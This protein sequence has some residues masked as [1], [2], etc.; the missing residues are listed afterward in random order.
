MLTDKRTEKY[1]SHLNFEQQKRELFSSLRYASYIQNALMP[2]NQ[3]IS[4]CFPEHFIFFQPR[5]IVS[6]DFYWLF[7]RK[8]NFFLVIGDCTGHGVP[9]AFMSILGINILNQIILQD[10]FNTAADILNQMREHVMKAL[11]QTGDEEEQKDGMDL[12]LCWFDVEHATLQYAGAFNPLYIVSQKKLLEI[13]ADR[14]PIGIHPAEESP[15][16]NNTYTLKDNDCLYLFTDGYPDQFG[17]SEGKKFKY[18]NFRNTLLNMAHK[19]MNDQHAF[20]EE[21][22][23]K[24]QG[25]EEQVDDILLMGIRYK[26]EHY[27]KI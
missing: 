13:P 5:D 21:V 26:H 10:R 27:H 23:Q 2:T 11:H 16:K 12:A 24:W 3:E 6:G 1:L 22:L 15:F 25:T 4:L 9:G 18:P 20:A 14:M 19:S 8:N 17:G 7:K